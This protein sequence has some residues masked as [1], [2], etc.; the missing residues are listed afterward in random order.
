M[1]LIYDYAFWAGPHPRHR[2]A[3]VIPMGDFNQ[4]DIS[5]NYMRTQIYMHSKIFVD[6]NKLKVLFLGEFQPI[7]K[8]IKNTLFMTHTQLV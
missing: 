2:E 4:T 1:P 7:Q 3:A 6:S 8:S 5:P